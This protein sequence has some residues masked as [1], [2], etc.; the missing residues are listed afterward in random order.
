MIR[1]LKVLT[2]YERKS[3]KRLMNNSEYE[4][5]IYPFLINK[6]YKVSIGVNKYGSTIK[7]IDT[8]NLNEYLKNIPTNIIGTWTIPCD[9][10][11]LELEVR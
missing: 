2:L 7:V 8:E 3:I 1:G 5:H 9:N 6:Q 10:D 4:L 11:I